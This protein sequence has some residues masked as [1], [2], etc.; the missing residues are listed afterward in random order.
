MLLTRGV[1]LPTG[2]G[3]L[4]QLK[5]DGARGQLRVVDGSIQLRTR[6]GRRCEAEFPE[7]VRAASGLPDVVLDGEIVV[8]DRRGSPDFAVLRSRLG[9]SA[10]RA[11]Q[12]AATIPAT[13]FAFDVLWHRGCDLR[14]RPLTERREVLESLPLAGA[15]AAVDFHTGGAAHVMAFARQRRLEGVVV[16]RADSPYQPGRRSPAWQ[17]F[18]IMT[19]EQVWVTAWRPGG[20][21]ELDRYWVGR[22]SD[23]RLA[24]TGEVSLGLGRGQTARLRRILQAASLSPARHG[25]IPVVPVVTMTVESH[26][27]GDWLRDP[28]ITSVDFDPTGQFRA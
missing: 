18:K 8:L 10:R 7:L 22:L 12:A 26:G 13:F 17:K 2:D 25:L 11:A 5:L 3:W 21:G 15:I 1:D 20:P 27:S 28:I 4:A 9:A 23:G 6:R 24:P 19:A 16:K 14:P